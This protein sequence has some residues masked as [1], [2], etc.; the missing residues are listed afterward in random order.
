[1][2]RRGEQGNQRTTNTK[3]KAKTWLY[4]TDCEKELFHQGPH[5]PFRDRASR[6]Q[7]KPLKSEWNKQQASER[8]LAREAPTTMP[9][10]LGP[11]EEQP[12]DGEPMSNEEPMLDP[13]GVD[14]EN[15]LRTS[16]PLPPLIGDAASQGEATTI[17]CLSDLPELALQSA[18]FRYLVEEQGG[19]DREA[20]HAPTCSMT[21]ARLN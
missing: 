11:E 8:A 10:T 17:T 2:Q 21:N 4:C 7:M 5:I 9:P 19:E 13:M 14:E 6:G 18:A 12:L 16:A 20:N 3:E 15:A 1:M